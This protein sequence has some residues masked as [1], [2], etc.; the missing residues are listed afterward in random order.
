MELQEA[1]GTSL[2]YFQELEHATRLLN[3]PGESLVL[4]TDFLYMVER[5][6]ICI[7]FLKSHVSYNYYFIRSP[8]HLV[9]PA[10]WVTAKLQRSRSIPLAFSAMYDAC[11]DFDQNVLCWLAPSAHAGCLTTAIR[12]GTLFLRMSLDFFFPS[13]YFTGCFRHRTNASS[14]HAVY[15]GGWTTRTT[16]WGIR[17]PRPHPPRGTRGPAF[18][19]SCRIFW[20]AQEPTCRASY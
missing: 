10:G 3:H 11:H 7:E 5:V 9:F 15:H 17:A 18:R 6:D 19:V 4:Q 14:L 13:S 16:P 20:R 2:E 8:A 1:I 12:T